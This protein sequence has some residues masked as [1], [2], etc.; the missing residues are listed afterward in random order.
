MGQVRKTGVRL[1]LGLGLGMFSLAAGQAGA[2]DKPFYDGKTLTIIVATNPG[3]GYDSYARLLAPQLQKYLP[4]STV[5]VKN[6]PGAGHIIG[7]NELYRAKPNGLTIGTFN[8]GLI[9]AQI[10]GMPGIQ[11][12]LAK[13][14]W[15]GTPATEPR[16]FVVSD[17]APFKSME[18][19]LA[20]KETVILSSAGVGS[21]A[22]T[23]ALIVA[24]ILGLTN[25]KLVSGYK[26]TEGEMAM[27][28]GEVH[29]QIGSIDSM[30][31]LIK[32]G[33][34]HPMM[35]IGDERLKEFPDVKT[36][37]EYA[38]PEQKAVVDLMVAQGLISRPYAAP[39]D[40]S[41][42]RLQVLREAFE[43]AW[44]DPEMLSHA[45]KMGRPIDFRGGE[46]V[47]KIVQG[48]LNQPAEVV[49]MLK[50]TMGTAKKKKKK[51]KE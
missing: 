47:A 21:S 51:K 30:L 31:P 25:M 14:S 10:V 48:A 22:H 28:R 17:K 50:D 6:V 18:D 7:A 8:K 39:P 43:K 41:P 38:P 15:L 40:V 20:G 16:L 32:N 45:E 34:A 4:G 9:T 49:A 24:R 1:V 29:G 23:D 36:L 46:T 12:D 33:D 37:Y 13:M 11:F 19:I 2:A 44:K 35:V 42:E 26:G 3:G 5:I 27:M